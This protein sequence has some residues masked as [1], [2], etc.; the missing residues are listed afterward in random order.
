MVSHTARGHP[1]PSPLRRG[2]AARIEPAAATRFGPAWPGP[3][4]GP[5]PALLAPARVILW[6]CGILHRFDTARITSAV[7][8]SSCLHVLVLHSLQCSTLLCCGDRVWERALLRRQGMPVGA[9]SLVVAPA[10]SPRP[11]FG[12]VPR[13]RRRHRLLSAYV[14]ALWACFSGGKEGQG[15]CTWISSVRVAVV[16]QDWQ[17]LLC[18]RRR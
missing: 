1:S 11:A 7:R 2:R 10:L 14:R 9:R 15:Y 16:C 8:S 6:W 4:L 12:Q 18:L 5:G 17:L 3:R 13:S